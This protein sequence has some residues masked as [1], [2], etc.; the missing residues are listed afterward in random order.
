[1]LYQIVCLACGYHRAWLTLLEAHAD[2]RRH[3]A[4]P[5]AIPPPGP[6]AY[7]NS[8]KSEP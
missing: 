8:A 1:M 2:G 3:D 6:P 5:C 7:P 4:A